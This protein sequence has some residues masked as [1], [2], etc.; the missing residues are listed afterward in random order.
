MSSTERRH[1]KLAITGCG[2]SGTRYI[3]LLLR[4]L[5]LELGHETLGRD[6]V[7]SWCL[8]V[9]AAYVPWGVARHEV[10]FEQVLHQVRH[11]LDVIPS[12]STFSDRSWSFICR[13]VPC[14]PEA[15]VLLRAAQYWHYWNLEVER[16]ADWRYRVEDLPLVFATLCARL[17]VAPEWSAFERVPGDINTRRC[18]HVL[19]WYDELCARLRIPLP[20][21]LRG[22]LAGQ[23][24]PSFAFT[25]EDLRRVDRGWCEQ[26]REQAHGYGYC[27]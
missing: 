16:I 20:V 8:A 25:W 6:G 9:D 17:G 26:V 14:D 1:K 7:V 22:R 21:S 2:R 12:V 10:V 19:H 13:Q 18:G 15:P 27:V 23:A 5:G 24:M 3:T 4:E 11:P